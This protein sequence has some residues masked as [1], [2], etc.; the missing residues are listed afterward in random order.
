VPYD[1]DAIIQGP[2]APNKH[3]DR[4]VQGLSPPGVGNYPA[5][6]A[7]ETFVFFY[8]AM[9]SIT[10]SQFQYGRKMVMHQ[11]VVPSE[12]PSYYRLKQMQD[13]MP[14]LN[15]MVKQ[16]PLSEK[17][18]ARAR[19]DH[20][21]RKKMQAK[22]REAGLL[23]AS[24]ET[25]AAEDRELTK[26]LNFKPKCVFYDPIDVIVRLFQW[27][28]NI[29]YYSFLPTRSTGGIVSQLTNSDVYGGM[30]MYTAQSVHVP[31]LTERV[32]HGQD[33]VYTHDGVTQTGEVI[34]IFQRSDENSWDDVTGAPAPGGLPAA[35]KRMREMGGG[36]GGN[37]KDTVDMVF[38]VR[39]F[40]TGAALRQ[41][42]QLHLPPDSSDESE[43]GSEL[44]AM[45][46]VEH[47]VAPSVVTGLRVI[48][49]TR[50][51]TIPPAK[52]LYST[53]SVLRTVID[54]ERHFTVIDTDVLPRPF[55]RL[56]N[57][58]KLKQRLRDLPSDIPVLRCFLTYFFDAFNVYSKLAHSTYGGYLTLAGLPR[59]VQDLLR[60]LFPVHLCAPG[61]DLREALKP[62][63]LRLRQMEEGIVV[64]M[65]PVIGKVFLVGGLGLVRADMPQ[66]HDFAEGLRQGATYGCRQCELHKEEFDRVLS[67]LELA[68]LHRT[69]HGTKEHRRRAQELAGDSL[70]KL[71]KILAK[72]GLSASE[73]PL[74]GLMFDCYRQMPYEPM[75]EKIGLV[76]K[77]LSTFLASM[78][79]LA[80]M[81]LNKRI[82]KFPLVPPW[83]RGVVQLQITAASPLSDRTIKSNATNAGRACG[84]L[85]LLLRGWVREDHFRHAAAD[86]LKQRAG[87][88]WLNR[89]VSVAFL[90]ARST[91]WILATYHPVTEEYYQ[92]LHLVVKEAREGC[93]ALWPSKFKNPT[94]HLG[95][96]APN[97][98]REQAGAVNAK[99][100]KGEGKHRQMARAAV[101]YNGRNTVEEVMLLTDNHRQAGMFVAHGGH[102]HLPL[103]KRP[104]PDFIR[105]VRDPFVQEMLAVASSSR[106]YVGDIAGSDDVPLA[107][108]T[109]KQKKTG[110]EDKLP[111]GSDSD[112]SATESDFSE[113]E[114]PDSDLLSGD[115]H[116]EADLLHVLADPTLLRT[117][118]APEEKEGAVMALFET[119]RLHDTQASRP[120]FGKQSKSIAVPE[121]LRAFASVSLSYRPPYCRQI[122]VRRY[123]SMK[124]ER[125]PQ[126]R[127]AYIQ[128]I[129]WYDTQ[130]WV[131][132]R[133]MDRVRPP[134]DNV[135]G[136]T[137]LPILRQAGVSSLRLLTDVLEPQHVMHRCDRS[138]TTTG[139]GF[140]DGQHG[141]HDLF[142]HNTNFIW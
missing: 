47:I 73:G 25:Q 99:T 46:D 37:P 29:E 78:T 15:V 76:K 48:A 79:D 61:S 110:T 13:A 129:L 87:E 20:A 52:N 34:G 19:A 1:F 94:T 4:V 93:A 27:P 128:A 51:E 40:A 131:V 126:V 50:V 54:S 86:L 118:Q 58:E 117:L 92:Q 123:Y 70:T 122:C 7:T 113:Q 102:V 43:V 134:M 57:S 124:F 64:D 67:P 66:G 23:S 142:L 18:I 127:V 2:G 120:G 121:G 56:F 136:A 10:R 35:L 111:P 98:A 22:R 91:S 116:I 63:V 107:A 72:V 104:G 96:H 59:H 39:P 62:F 42:G 11:D 31:A 89:V 32:S 80:R 38:Q 45:F 133:W 69:L 17:A 75:H 6:N 112:S 36:G 90:V 21:T 81:E 139:A 16:V 88:D 65:G 82:K 100:G 97:Q 41:M 125:P 115:N 105:Q 9:N 77:F 44:F 138:C 5:K 130:F 140:E 60:C 30:P 119:L 95:T 14:L 71:A 55:H 12:Y 49:R 141:A 132:I 101:K 74:A 106:T 3:R 83:S 85:G 68:F 135:D 8:H 84:V 26:A 137:G 109:V 33:I 28:G 103:D 24:L 108:N 114:N 53:R